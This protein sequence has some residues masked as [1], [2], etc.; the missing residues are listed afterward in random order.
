MAGSVAFGFGLTNQ[1]WDNGVLMNM[2]VFTSMPSLSQWHLMLFY[3]GK[4]RRVGS[5]T[6][7]VRNRMFTRL[8]LKC[9]L[10]IWRWRRRGWSFIAL[11]TYS[12][13]TRYV[14]VKQKIQNNKMLF[15]HLLIM[16]SRPPN[17]FHPLSPSYHLIHHGDWYKSS[18]QCNKVVSFYKVPGWTR[19]TYGRRYNVVPQLF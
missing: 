10:I 6:V 17:N 14:P 8:D 4:W 1:W 9:D 3:D 7:S 18:H 13:G 15:I 2:H 19:K 16:K 12:K 11:S 5:T